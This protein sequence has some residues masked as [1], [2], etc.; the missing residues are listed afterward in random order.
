MLNRFVLPIFLNL[1]IL[2]HSFAE[3]SPERSG[4]YLS[5]GLGLHA[6]ESTLIIDDYGEFADSSSGLLTSFKVGGYLNPTFAIYYIREAAW[7]TVDTYSYVAGISGVGGTYYFKP[8]SG[9]YLEFAVGFGDY[10]LRDFDDT[11]VGTAIQI[12]AGFELTENIQLGGS[13]ISTD[14]P[15]DYYYDVTYTNF[16]VAAKVEYKL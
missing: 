15:D 6:T 5:G 11:D 8:V 12:G 3:D 7:W 4:F 13:L 9:G 16:I 1:A 10:T 14:I 2:P